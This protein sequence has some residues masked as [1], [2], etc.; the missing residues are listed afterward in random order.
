MTNTSGTSKT[1]SDRKT[2]MASATVGFEYKGLSS[3]VTLS[4]E[5]SKETSNTFYQELDNTSETTITAECKGK[6]ASDP[7][8]IW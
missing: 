2:L 4:A 6:T 8:V 5:A 7:V 3:S 1:D